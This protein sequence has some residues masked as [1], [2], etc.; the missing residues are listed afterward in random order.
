MDLTNDTTFTFL[1]IQNE[2][3][4]ERAVSFNLCKKNTEL[5]TNF[6]APNNIH[7]MLNQI[8][9]IGQSMT[10][11]FLTMPLIDLLPHS[12]IRYKNYL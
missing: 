9:S 12:R 6:K 10:L 5:L 2:I 1:T 8:Y 7:S 3:L 11:V 4:C